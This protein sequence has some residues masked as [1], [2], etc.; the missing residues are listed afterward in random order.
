MN[1]E[2]APIVLAAMESG[3]SLRQACEHVGVPAGTFLGWCDADP[4]LAEHYARTRERML[5]MRA[6][7]LE[8]IGERAAQAES[9]VEVAGLRLLSDNRKWLLSKLMPKRYGDKLAVGGEDDLPPIQGTLDV[10]ALSTQA[11][12]EIMRAK[13]AAVGG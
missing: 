3:M 6:E 10:S 4:E 9:A 13:D 1:Y 12:A 8:D 5:D 11:L 2:R 7:E